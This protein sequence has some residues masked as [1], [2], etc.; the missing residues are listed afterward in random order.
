MAAKLAVALNTIGTNDV[1]TWRRFADSIDTYGALWLYQRDIL[2]NHPPFLAHALPVL[3]W[4]ARHTALGF[5]FWMRLP[6]ILADFG[7]LW[8]LAAIVRPT[9]RLLLL[10]ALCPISLFVA[11]F[12]GNTDPIL[13]FLILLAI[14]FLERCN[15][16][17]AAAVALGLAGSIKIVAIVAAPALL[18][19]VESNRRR[20][21]FVTVAFA[22]F[23]LLAAPYLFQ[24]PGVI[25]RNVF[26]YHSL[27][28]I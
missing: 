26:G 24:A 11:G 10:F 8:L 17:I 14:F 19:Y 27:E 21:V 22:T 20:V 9:P 15:W 4:L 12:H 3:N 25:I 16:L 28:G 6:A 1:T 23:L 2:F 13:I 18:F 5:P 7:S